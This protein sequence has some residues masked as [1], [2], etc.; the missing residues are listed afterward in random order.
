MGLVLY[1]VVIQFNKHFVGYLHYWSAN[2]GLTICAGVKY[3]SFEMTARSYLVFFVYFLL[4]N[5]QTNMIVINLA[6][7]ASSDSLRRY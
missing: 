7:V 6:R 2:G 1:L 3:V 4:T 5:C